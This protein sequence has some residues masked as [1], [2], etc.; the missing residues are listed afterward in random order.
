MMIV[1]MMIMMMMMDMMTIIL[2]VN[3][4]RW[5]LTVSFLTMI[6]MTMKVVKGE[7]L[8]MMMMMTLRS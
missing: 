1:R 8:T 4:C 7:E 2:A 3:C 6:V 5:F